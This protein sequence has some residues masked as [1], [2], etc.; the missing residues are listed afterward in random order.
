M[1][2]YRTKDG[3]LMVPKRAEADG[4]LGDG[5]VTL[6]PGEAEF[7]KW[8]AWYEE[9]GIRPPLWP[10][11]AMA[12]LQQSE[13]SVFVE[14]ARHAEVGQPFQGPSGKWF[15][16]RQDGKTVPAK[17]PTKQEPEKKTRAKKK[18]EPV[19]QPRKVKAEP[20]AKPQKATPESALAGVKGHLD[21]TAP[22]GDV[23]GHL[24]AVSKLTKD[25][26]QGVM[27]QVGLEGKKS[28]T[29]TSMLARLG[30]KMEGAKTGH[31]AKAHLNKVN[32]YIKTGSAIPDADL[33]AVPGHLANLSDDQLK[34][35]AARIPS[36]DSRGERIAAITKA[37]E[38][39]NAKKQ[40]A[41]A[42]PAPAPAPAPPEE[43]EDEDEGDL[44]L[45]RNPNRIRYDEY[46]GANDN[47]TVT[48]ALQAN[49]QEQDHLTA[50]QKKVYGDAVDRVVRS[51]PPTA[52]ALLRKNLESVFF[53]ADT[54]GIG[55][56]WEQANDQKVPAGATVQ[57]FYT[58]GSSSARLDG[59]TK[60][61]TEGPFTEEES[62]HSTYAHEMTHALDGWF[63]FSGTAAWSGAFKEEIE[64]SWLED[65]PLSEYGRSHSSEGF[66]EFGRLL[67]GTDVDRAEVE[68]RFPKCSAFFK[69]KG[70]WPQ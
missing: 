69:S 35:L 68:K 31:A 17:D 47:E 36:G 59:L 34:T 20:V 11:D 66:A 39:Y 56:A 5:F 29:K 41:K 21:G 8:S 13:W 63:D 26:L 37:L 44:G 54:D 30:T 42:P 43:D 61:D 22:V 55:K 49:L 9:Q 40:P 58:P 7:E 15:V 48:N 24:A 57:G 6:K 2:A 19:A 4:M 18:E 32:G 51:M 70:L 60:Y 25:Q 10:L 67:Y 33:K 27:K 38:G 53:H 62:V 50:E 23:Q 12:V 65:A 45:G 3:L 64:G 46:E 14:T 52:A 1:Q 16:K 28:E